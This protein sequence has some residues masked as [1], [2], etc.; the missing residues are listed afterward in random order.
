MEEKSM[1][2]TRKLAF[3]DVFKFAR[4]INKTGTKNDI[5]NLM[6]KGNQK[7]ADSESI[8]M[9]FFGMLLDK[10]PQAESEIYEFLSGLTD[11]SAKDVA[12]AEISEVL[13]LFADII[14]TNKDLKSFFISA[15]RSPTAGLSTKS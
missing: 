12:G 13:E 3:N 1:K 10:L 9:E 5:I 14:A 6:Q 15:L 2:S 8:G 11:K 4:I 7:G